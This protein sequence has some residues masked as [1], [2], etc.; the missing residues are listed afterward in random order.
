MYTNFNDA[1]LQRLAEIINWHKSKYGYQDDHDREIMTGRGYS[2]MDK[3][4]AAQRIDE[5]EKELRKELEDFEESERRK[6][7]ASKLE[8][9]EEEKPVF[10]WERIK[11]Y[12]D[13]R[14]NLENPAVLNTTRMPYKILQAFGTR[15]FPGPPNH[16][17]SSQRI[18]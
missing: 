11:V 7:E 18:F 10:S 13:G 16:W 14:T 1:K 9:M 6:A 5:R 12:S 4:Q 2:P 3:S 17:V 15:Y 8:K